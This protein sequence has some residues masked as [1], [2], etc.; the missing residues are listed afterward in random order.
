MI[1]SKSTKHPKSSTSDWRDRPLAR[2]IAA[3]ALGLASGFLFGCSPQTPEREPPLQRSVPDPNT[4]STRRTEA[5][6]EPAR[7]SPPATG[8][9]VLNDVTG[10]T[11]ITFKHTDGSSGK[12]YVMEQVSA[13]LALFDYDGD[14]DID[15]YFLNGSPLRGTEVD[16][17][18]RNALYRNEGG[19]KF[20][21]VTDEAGVGDT[22]Y[23]LGVAAADY[24][25]DGDQDLYVNNYGPNVLYRNNGD[26]TFTDVTRE[27]GVENGHKVGAGVCFLDMDKDGDLDLYAASYVKF[28][29]DTYVPVFAGDIP[30][31]PGPWRFEP[32]G[33]TL[34]RNNSDG[35][36][37]DVSVPS[38]IAACAGTGMGMVC[39]DYDR[40]GD[41]D[42]F[43]CNDL[44]QNF[45]FEND[46][47]G[48]FHEVALAVGLAYNID[49]HT[50]ASMG[51][52]CGDYDNDGWLD[53]FMT[54]Y[55]GE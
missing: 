45:F 9:I 20:T 2:R 7:P 39:C 47:T 27:A 49:G 42:V 8:P 33:D 18:P 34:Y 21:D 52:D 30:V 14:G 24:D 5:P 12:R 46:G 43:V 51:A 38:G 4:P 6:Q 31:Y 50:N 29:Y 48:K 13:G 3:G 32:E 22:G 44:R 17:P 54:N 15:I 36:F 28:S 25:N 35:T 1:G 19:W 55:Q 26:G 41:T 16:V 10:E 11:G 40:D 37:T 23:G 53:L